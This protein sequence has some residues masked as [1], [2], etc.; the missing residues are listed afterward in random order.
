[1]SPPPYSPSG[2][3]KAVSAL[4][5]DEREQRER[6]IWREQQRFQTATGPRHLSAV[7][8]G[9]VLSIE[10]GQKQ[11]KD[12]KGARNCM[13][14]ATQRLQLRIRHGRW[15]FGENGKKSLGID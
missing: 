12:E 3:L 11:S 9:R 10:F 13:D 15:E 1:L 4:P 7:S 8:G 6:A 2:P 5:A 14:V